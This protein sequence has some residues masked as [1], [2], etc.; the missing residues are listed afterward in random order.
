V[1]SK[2]NEESLGGALH[3]DCVRESRKTLRSSVT[4]L[5]ATLRGG[6]GTRKEELRENA[7]FQCLISQ[8]LGHQLTRL[9][10]V[11]RGGRARLIEGVGRRVVWGGRS[12]KEALMDWTVYFYWRFKG[13]KG[14][15]GGQ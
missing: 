2:E 9:K 14:V 7:R 6:V 13:K 4:F 15:R 1:I 5:N 11:Q 10:V 8:N 12:G 3:P